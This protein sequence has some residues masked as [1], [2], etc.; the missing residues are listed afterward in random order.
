MPRSLPLERHVKSSIRLSLLTVKYMPLV[1]PA[2]CALARST[3]HELRGWFMELRLKQLLLLASM[4]LLLMHCGV[5][6]STRSPSW[7]S[8]G[9]MAPRPS[10]QNKSLRKQRRNFRCIKRFH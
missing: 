3:F 6:A 1:S 4:I 8:N 10:L 2:P 7:R 5:L 9:Q